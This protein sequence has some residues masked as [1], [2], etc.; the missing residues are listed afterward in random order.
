M[1]NILGYSGNEELAFIPRGESHWLAKKKRRYCSK[2]S[3]RIYRR[4]IREYKQTKAR[5]QAICQ[6]YSLEDLNP[7]YP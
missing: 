5:C 3:S 4:E 1:P 6:M 7:I 2:K